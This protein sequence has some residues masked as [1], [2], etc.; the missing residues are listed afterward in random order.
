[1]QT[2]KHVLLLLN[3]NQQSAEAKTKALISCAVAVQLI[4]AFVFATGI[5]QFLYLYPKFHDSSFL[6]W[7]YSKAG[8]CLTLVGNPEDPSQVTRS[9]SQK[10]VHF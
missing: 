10:K 3:K 9:V 4:S 6:L 1:M 5:V 7:V 2:S 8:L